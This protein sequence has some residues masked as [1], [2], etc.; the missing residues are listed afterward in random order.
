MRRNRLKSGNR[1]FKKVIVDGNEDEGSIDVH[2]MVDR[3]RLLRM[4]AV[5][6]GR[7]KSFDN[8]SSLANFRTKN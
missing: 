7:V 1:V 6:T 5:Y 4:Q 8:K 3:L 2:T